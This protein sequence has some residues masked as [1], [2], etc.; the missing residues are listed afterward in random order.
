[1]SGFELRLGQA[2]ERRRRFEADEIHRFARLARDPRPSL[3]GSEPRVPEGLIGGLFSDLLG[4][5]LPG[6]GTNWLKQRLEF[7]GVAHAGEPLVARVE[8][9]RLRPDKRLVN[10]RTT[11]RT[12]DGR[13]IADGEA[14]VLALEMDDAV[15]RAAGPAGGPVAMG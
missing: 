7:H 10:L 13:L 4:T 2:A 3:Q 6:R 11:A 14:L 15:R 8:I 9:V 12:E 5:E 1:M